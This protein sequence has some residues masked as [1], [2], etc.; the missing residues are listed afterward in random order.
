[1]PPTQRKERSFTVNS[2]ERP[3]THPT[4][5]AAP[6]DGRTDLLQ[7]AVGRWQDEVANRPLVNIHRRARDGVW[8]QVIRYAGGDPEALIGPNHDALLALQ[9]EQP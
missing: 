8:R 9:G 4:P 1:M 6:Q 2:S 7:W 5:A 3:D